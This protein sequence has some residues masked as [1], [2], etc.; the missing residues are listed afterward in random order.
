[1]NV[2]IKSNFLAINVNLHVCICCV[3]QNVEE[4]KYKAAENRNIEVQ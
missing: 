4:W 1:M 2:G 3:L